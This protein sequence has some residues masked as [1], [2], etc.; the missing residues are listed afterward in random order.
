MNHAL[1]HQPHVQHAEVDEGRDDEFE[2]PR[3][4][5]GMPFKRHPVYAPVR[6]WDDEAVISSNTL[7]SNVVPDDVNLVLVD[8][9]AWSPAAAETSLP[10]PLATEGEHQH[11]QHQKC[12]PWCKIFCPIIL[13]FFLLILGFGLG[14][15]LQVVPLI[16]GLRIRVESL[17]LSLCSKPVLAEVMATVRNPSSVQVH[18]T[19]FDAVLKVKRASADAQTILQVKKITPF[20][21]G[22]N[23][24]PCNRSHSCERR[25]KHVLY[26][27]CA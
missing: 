27:F 9:P 10:L 8:Q 12:R 22:G 1:K 14:I 2:I 20:A 18:I 23:Q 19:R 11:K 25:G 13:V 7:T 21:D 4:P 17:R 6:R 3:G 5:H 26:A 24:I 16:S 15:A